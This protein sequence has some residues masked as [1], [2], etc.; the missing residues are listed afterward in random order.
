VVT[1]AIRLARER[2]EWNARRLAMSR[3]EFLLSMMGAATTLLALDACS[4]EEARSRPHPTRRGPTEPGGTYEI[5]PDATMDPDEAE[6]AVGGEEFVFDI[7]GHLLEYDFRPVLNG[8]DF[9][10]AFPQQNCGEDDPRDCYSIERFLG[11]FFLRSDTSM[12]VL[13]AL[14]IHPEGSPLSMAVMEE[15][16]RLAEALCRDERILLHAQA[17]PNVGPPAA[18]LQ[19]MAEVVDRHPVVAWKTFTHFPDAFEAGE[20]GWWLDDHEPGVAQVGEAFIERCVELGVPTICSHKGLSNGSRF[21]SPADIGPAARR[22]PEANFVAYHSG[23][24]AGVTEGPYTRATRGVGVN[25]LISSI[26]G[27]GIR[28]NSNVYAEIGSTWWYVMRSPTQAAHVLG[29]L[30]RYVGQDNVLWGTDSIFYGSPQDQIQ[31][32]RSFQISEEFQER[33]GYPKLTKEIKAKVLGLNGA[34][35]YGVDPASAPCRFTRRELERI[36][37]ALPAENRTYGPTTSAEV[38]AFRADHQGWP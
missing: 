21:A 29:K 4:R 10:R 24:E 1:E 32:F 22:H 13:S 15:T 33:Y 7:Q 20:N 38:A 25:R 30:L 34:R 14:P 35:L 31:A 2:S 28:P 12:I 36:R 26:R 16:R 11:E 37:R 18:S 9:W 3:R 5:P 6:G 23:F 27:N 17:L 8:E 19:A